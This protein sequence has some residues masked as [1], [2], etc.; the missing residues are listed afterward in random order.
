MT[1]SKVIYSSELLFGLAFSL[2]SIESNTVLVSEALSRLVV[3]VGQV[4]WV[5]AEA[6]SSGFGPWSLDLEGAVTS[7]QTP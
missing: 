6:L 3:K 4:H 2:G 7:S 5:A 1:D